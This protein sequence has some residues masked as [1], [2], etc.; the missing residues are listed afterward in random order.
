MPSLGLPEIIVIMALALV[1]FGPKRLPEIGRKVGKAL[2]E[3]QKAKADLMENV[4]AVTE[5]LRQ[6]AG[7]DEEPVETYEAAPVDTL[8]YA[9]LP[10]ETDTYAEPTL[11]YGSDFEPAD[12]QP[13][14]EPDISLRAG[15]YDEPVAVA[16]RAD[17]APANREE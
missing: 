9:G 5:D 13:V 11:P 3:F 8:D 10:P 6:S 14:G 16:V 2:R 17:A 4:T 12:N 15:G 1:V 7:L